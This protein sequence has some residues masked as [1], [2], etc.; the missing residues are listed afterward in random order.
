MLVF[1]DAA[2]YSFLCN[3]IHSYIS[4]KKYAIIIIVVLVVADDIIIIISSPQTSGACLL[5]CYQL[6]APY[7]SI[8][9]L[10]GYSFAYL[11]IH[12]FV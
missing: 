10:S 1:V 4:K 3:S 12:L 2:Y 9:L 8:W 5:P 7:I 6:S 11:V